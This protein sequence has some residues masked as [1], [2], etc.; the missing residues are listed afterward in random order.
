MLIH[1]PWSSLQPYP[2]I[3]LPEYLEQSAHRFQD[4]PCL[5]NVDGAEYTF[6]RIWET[7]KRLGRFLQDQ[8]IQKGDRVAILSANVP[9]YVV[10]FQ[11]IIHAGAV[12]TPL[13]PLYKE[14][15]LHHQLED[16]DANA[17]FTMRFLQTPV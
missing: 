16:C 13:N 11:G 2:V 9:E 3:T 17:I 12:V 10:A 1:S 6:R 5:V 7:G 4:K 15:E 8:G 14:R